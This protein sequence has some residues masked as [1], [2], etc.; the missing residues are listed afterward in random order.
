MVGSY[1]K[2]ITAKP[3]KEE[4]R[5][6]KSSIFLTIFVPLFFNAFA[7]S[8]HESISGLRTK[9]G[10]SKENF[11]CCCTLVVVN[12][13]TCLK[14]TTITKKKSN[15]V[16]RRNNSCSFIFEVF[17]SKFYV[18]F[19]WRRYCNYYCEDQLNSLISTFL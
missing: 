18:F 17:H 12:H 6:S 13:K 3:K 11:G 4:M 10:E 19:N 2:R 16:G 9:K 5:F 15:V 7:N 14:A 8:K 1:T